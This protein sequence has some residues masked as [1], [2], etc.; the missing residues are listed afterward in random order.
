MNRVMVG[1]TRNVNFMYYAEQGLMTAVI[2]MP[3]DMR[4]RIKS[5]EYRNND[6]I[7][8]FEPSSDQPAPAPVSPARQSPA[9][10][11]R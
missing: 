9:I 2:P 11:P 7:V 6:M 4:W 3:T 1:F 5:Y 10:R 8:I